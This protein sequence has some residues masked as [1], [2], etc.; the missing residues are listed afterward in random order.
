VGFLDDDVTDGSVFFDF[1]LPGL[2]CAGTIGVS[3]TTAPSFVTIKVE[4]QLL[5]LVPKKMLSGFSVFPSSLL[6]I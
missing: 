6:K 4:L 5:N 1:R 2:G 3:T